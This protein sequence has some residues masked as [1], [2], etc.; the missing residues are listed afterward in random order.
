MAKITLLLADDHNVVRW[1][2][3]ALLASDPEFEV[4]GEAGSGR[5]AITL[6][7]QL[8]PD[9]VVMD[10]AMPLLN[11]M[12]ATR[13]ITAECPSTKVIVLSAYDDDPHVEQALAMEAAGYLL[14]HT[15]ANDLIRAVREVH[16]GNAYFSP[17]IAERL[18]EKRCAQLELPKPQ[19]ERARRL[20]VREA[21]VL[22]LVAEGY[23]N[24]QI[25]DELRL[26]VKTVEKHRQSLMSKLKLHCIADLVQYAAAHGAIEMN[27]VSSILRPT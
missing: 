2:L 5:E 22:Q 4:V 23:P 27:P 20:S 24:K 15:A 19:T 3:R 11:G 1:G 8:K 17:A 16:A 25:A 9:V 7:Q 18:R 14:K 10:L 26:S 6:V 21:E 12:E 13:Q